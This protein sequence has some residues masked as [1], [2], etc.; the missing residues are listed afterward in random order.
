MHQGQCREGCILSKPSPCR[1]EK[2][3][4]SA[5]QLPLPPHPE[6][7][8]SREFSTF[9]C[10]WAETPSGQGHEDGHGITNPSAVRRKWMASVACNTNPLFK[11]PL[12]PDP[13]KG[14]DLGSAYT[15]Q[16]EPSRPR[17]LLC[18]AECSV[19][20][21]ASLPAA[22]IPAMSAMQC[23]PLC[24]QRVRSPSKQEARICQAPSVGE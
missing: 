18:S 8:E 12:T 21:A 16:V 5:E 6:L 24:P 17:P 13:Q 14:P 9:S 20:A 22:G 10:F 3:K 7:R 15:A 11:V 1:K 4:Q 2:Q 23:P 19:A